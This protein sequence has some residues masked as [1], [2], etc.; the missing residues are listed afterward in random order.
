M[1]APQQRRVVAGEERL[2]RR[3]LLL[4]GVDLTQGQRGEKALLY[5]WG[6]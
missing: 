5:G 6:N 3:C 2:L 4:A 1:K